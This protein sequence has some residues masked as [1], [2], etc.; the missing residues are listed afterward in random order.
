MN[1]CSI[2]HQL[3]TLHMILLIHPLSPT[4]LRPP[5]LSNHTIRRFRLHP[6]PL[7][8]IPIGTQCSPIT[9]HVTLLHRPPGLWRGILEQFPEH[10]I[11]SGVSVGLF[12]CLGIFDDFPFD[13]VPVFGPCATRRGVCYSF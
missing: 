4:Q 5:L 7:N 11:R 3:T 6:A 13:G 2:I 8:L 1:K 9:L 10:G 12:P